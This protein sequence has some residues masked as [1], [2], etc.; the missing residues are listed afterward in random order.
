MRK[1]ETERKIKA[2][3]LSKHFFVALMAFMCVLALISL[4]FVFLRFVGVGG[5]EIK[6]STEYELSELISAS[7]IRSGDAM[8]SVRVKTAEKLLLEKCP[9]LKSVDVKKKF[10]NKIVFKVEERVLGWYLQVGDDFYALD[11]DLRILLETYDEQSLIDRG[12]TKLVLPELESAVCDELPEFG[13]DDEQLIGETLKIIDSFRT[14][15]MKPR[16]T[17]LDLSNRFEITLIIDS[18][19]E[20]KLGDM[21]NIETKLAT[22]KSTIARSIE[23]G[24]AGGEL[25]MITPT[26]FSFR[27]YFAQ[28]NDE[29]AADESEVEKTE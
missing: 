1:D 28:N 4:L 24:Y 9:Y 27:G 20:V 3:I 15:E 11:Y 12:L 25:N 8:S 17:Y 16:L 13:N 5:F 7:G 10:P 21:S 19:F 22:I 6:G 23:K 29:N 18:T 26:S 2:F 14:H